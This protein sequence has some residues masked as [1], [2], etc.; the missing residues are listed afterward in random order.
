[1]ART[2]AQLSQAER[3]KP[4]RLQAESRSARQIAAALD[5]APSTITWEPKRNARADGGYDPGG[6]QRR[7]R[8]LHEWRFRGL[9]LE[10]D[11]D[12]REQ[13]QAMLAAGH[14]PQQAAERLAREAGRR[15]ISHESIY[16]FLRRQT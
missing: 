1:M 2:H 12:L 8:P 4:A 16:R 15:V 9:R 11:A 3:R 7:T 6:A 13:V 14:S 10:R 5:R